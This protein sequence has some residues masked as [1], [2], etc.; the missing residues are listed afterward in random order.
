MG[1]DILGE[2]VIHKPWYNRPMPAIT[3]ETRAKRVMQVMSAFIWMTKGKSKE[4]SCKLVGIST[5][6]Y[7]R[8]IADGG[9][10]IEALQTTVADV[11]RQRLAQIVAVQ[12]VILNH[13]TRIALEETDPETLIKIGKYIDPIRKELEYKHGVNTSTDDAETYLLSGPQTRFEESKM[14]VQQEFSR[15]NIKTRPDG[16]VDLS[17]PIKREIIDAESSDS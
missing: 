7:D 15:V 9:D 13:L 16:S 1:Q 8:Y 11:E 5:D 12:G 10:I 2:I 3:T 4:E 17:L 6:I 14:Q